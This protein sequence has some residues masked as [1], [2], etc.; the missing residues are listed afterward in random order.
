MGYFI[1]SKLYY[2][3]NYIQEMTIRIDLPLETYFS[4]LDDVFQY[5]L[6]MTVFDMSFTYS[7]Y[8]LLIG[9]FCAKFNYRHV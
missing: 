8:A 1:V 6:A 7:N 4:C 3:V 2:I 9:S 5:N